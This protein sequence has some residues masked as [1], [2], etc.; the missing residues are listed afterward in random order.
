MISERDS[1]LKLLE[2][3]A[4]V[5]CEEISQLE[6]QL[7]E[8]KRN[9]ASEANNCISI[10]NAF[11]S[12]AK[13]VSYFSASS[14]EQSNALVE[15]VNGWT[16]LFGKRL[17]TVC[18]QVAFLTEDYKD[19]EILM[20][21]LKEQLSDSRGYGERLEQDRLEL[22]ERMIE[23]H[24]SLA[25]ETRI[26][27]QAHREIERLQQE[28]ENA[29][30]RHQQERALNDESKLSFSGDIHR[31]TERLENAEKRA[32]DAAASN[33]K[34][35]VNGARGTAYLE[36]ECSR[37]RGL[38]DHLR[39]VN[40]KLQGDVKAASAVAAHGR[41]FEN[42]LKIS[43]GECDRLRSHIA[44]LE[45]EVR[46]KDAFHLHSLQE[47]QEAELQRQRQHDDDIQQLA[48]DV[49]ARKVSIAYF[50]IGFF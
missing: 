37:L 19:R 10:R 3:Q 30:H 46:E 13:E 15:R 49:A 31:L 16:T 6:G 1:S 29:D 32:Q 20:A 39:L 42:R 47:I 44:D 36:G 33:A 35:F 40:A 28:L 5:R 26:R 23:M 27:E 18:D 12:I 4:Q 7:R 25:S 43:L 8:L 34:L 38:V 2:H 22:E 9:I 17:D 11:Q 50:I 41:G 45:A 48:G 21:D 14:G 24:E